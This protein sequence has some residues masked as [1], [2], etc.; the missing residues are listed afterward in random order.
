M[1]HYRLFNLQAVNLII[2]WAD[3][4]KFLILLPK[5]QNRAK[6]YESAPQWHEGEGLPKVVGG[7]RK[8]PPKEGPGG[9]HSG[10]RKT[11]RKQ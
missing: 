7:Y 1:A 6:P 9:A 3:Q 5:M 4:P 10:P 11:I 2:I 8:K